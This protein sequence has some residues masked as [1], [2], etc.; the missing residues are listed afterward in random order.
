MNII[1]TLL[2]V[3]KQVR[4]LPKTNNIMESDTFRQIANVIDDIDNVIE[5]YDRLEDKIKEENTNE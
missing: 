3:S 2:E 4:N 5:D 1:Q